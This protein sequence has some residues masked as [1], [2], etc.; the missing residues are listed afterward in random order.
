MTIY[1]PGLET[2]KPISQTLFSTADLGLSQGVL[3]SLTITGVPGSNAK[4]AP[5]FNKQRP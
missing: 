1:F 2:I 3:I 4:H 5:K